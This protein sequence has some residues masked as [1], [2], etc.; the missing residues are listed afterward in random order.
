MANH[1]SRLEDPVT[2]ARNTLAA[3]YPEVAA[4]V[5]TVLA[6]ARAGLGVAEVVASGGK[7]C[8][9][10]GSCLGGLASVLLAPDLVTAVRLN[11]LAGGDCCSRANF[12]GAVF[13]ARD[14]VEA[15]PIE[16][17]EK[18]SNI[19]VIFEKCFESCCI[20]YVI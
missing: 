13:G 11:I 8:S 5:D 19:E 6:A 18:V 10:P 3:E 12:I 15:I 14:G 2:A 7:E 9:L 16:W 17:M 20:S 4:G 1:I